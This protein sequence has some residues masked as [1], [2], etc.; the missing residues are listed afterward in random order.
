M[1][2]GKREG[3]MRDWLIGLQD[4]KDGPIMGSWE[5]DGG[6]IGTHCGRVGSTSMALLTLEVYYVTCRCTSARTPAA[7]RSSTA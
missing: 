3:G 4:K 2:D 6:T 1:K 5:S 7:S